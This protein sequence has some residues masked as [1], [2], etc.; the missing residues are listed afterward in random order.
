M[1]FVL[2]LSF[3]PEI[4][5]GELVSGE[6]VLKLELVCRFILTGRICPPK[7]V[8]GFH[9]QVND[10]SLKNVRQYINDLLLHVR[11]I[12]LTSLLSGIIIKYVSGLLS[13]TQENGFRGN[14]EKRRNTLKGGKG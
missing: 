3:T 9:L 6:I 14:G 7:V 13:R 8:F 2:E 1:V 5:S 12:T 10:Y 4:S 11:R